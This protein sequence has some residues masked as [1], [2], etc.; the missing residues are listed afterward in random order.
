M[1]IRFFIIIT[2]ALLFTGAVTNSFADD[3]AQK[4]SDDNN[5]A[6]IY[7]RAIEIH[8]SSTTR[9]DVLNR[10]ITFKTG[11]ALDTSALR[12]TRS[13]LIKTQL[14][15]KVDVFPNMRED[16]AY[17]FIILKEAVRQTLGYSG[18]YGTHKYGDK[19]LW[20]SAH[21]DAG[22]NNF[23]GRLEELSGGISFWERR[24]ARASWHKPFLSTPYFIGTAA[25]VS[26]YPD[27]WYPIDY[28]DISAK[29][30]AGRYIG[31]HSQVSLSA[32]PTLRHRTLKEEIVSV[33][34]T[35]LISLNAPDIYE[36]FGVLV[37]INDLR[38]KRFDP[39]SGWYLR[40]EISTNRLYYDLTKPFVQF[41]NDF[42][43]YQP[44][45]FDDMA[46]LRFSMTLRDNNAGYY[47]RL[48]Y[49]DAGQIRGYN[50]K[51]A[52]QGFT[53]NSSVLMS[54]KYHKPIWKAPALNMP[55][56]NMVYSGVQEISYRADATLIAD[57]ARIYSDPQG[58]L[59]L[60][61]HYQEA[62]G[63]GGGIRV[64]IPEIRQSGCID[65]VYGRRDSKEGNG[66]EWKPVL[67]VY[68]DLFY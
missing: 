42:R 27:E 5:N 9:P 61:G 28:R 7:I 41:K 55:L 14:Y 22:L 36:A 62:A 4:S 44:L 17:V 34:D 40:S 15:E 16:G 51:E 46:A 57:Y 45:L 12:N 64:V 19:K 26:I 53:A 59:L 24:G 29:A 49:G 18:E 31:R 23:R 37:L 1:T 6:V 32:I 68:L 48:L 65:I 47:H 10:F 43:F 21:A 67:H 63:L 25:A 13:N 3:T 30:A 58:A 66:Y 35:T 50:Q 60:K 8:G 56:I 38:N 2:I 20:W 52:G 11:D 33:N 54:A 39:Q